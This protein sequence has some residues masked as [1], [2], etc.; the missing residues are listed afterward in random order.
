[1]VTT[2]GKIGILNHL[3]K[4]FESEKVKKSVKSGEITEIGTPTTDST[5]S[6]NLEFGIINHL[7]S[8]IQITIP[9]F[10]L[11]KISI[12]PLQYFRRFHS[13]AI[14]DFFFSLFHLILSPAKKVENSERDG[15]KNQGS[16]NRDS[17]NC[18]KSDA[19]LYL[20][21]SLKTSHRVHHRV[22]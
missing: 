4:W 7:H 5:S 17:R 8:R 15:E 11:R 19:S 18:A 20:Y 2:N 21:S 12:L 9:K 22:S 1:M 14:L 16:W 10:R 3:I 6:Q 13:I